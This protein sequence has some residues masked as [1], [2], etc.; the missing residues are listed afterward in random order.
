MVISQAE[1]AVNR[2]LVSKFSPQ[3]VKM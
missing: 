2:L 3:L 1:L